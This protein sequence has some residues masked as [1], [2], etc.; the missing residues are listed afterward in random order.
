[1]DAELRAKWVAALRSGEFEQHRRS[2]CDDTRSA[3]CCLGVLAV[4]KDPNAYLHENEGD[5]DPYLEID[6]MIGGRR[7]RQELV[8]LNDKEGKSFPEIADWIE[9]KIPAVAVIADERGTE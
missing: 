4:I 5:F 2:L 6:R 8:N 7:Q 9:Q 1:M 3:F